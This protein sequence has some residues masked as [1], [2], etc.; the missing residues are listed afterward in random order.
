MDETHIRWG[1]RIDNAAMALVRCEHGN[2][3]SALLITTTDR[4]DRF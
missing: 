3:R 4:A 1:S 2:L